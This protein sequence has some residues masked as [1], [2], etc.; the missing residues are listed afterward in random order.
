LELTGTRLQYVYL[1]MPCKVLDSASD[2][3]DDESCDDYSADTS[4]PIDDGSIDD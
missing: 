3:S 2:T 4:L 1:Y